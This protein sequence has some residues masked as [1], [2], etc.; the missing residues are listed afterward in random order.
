[1]PDPPTRP[2][3][4]NPS[5][6]SPKLPLRDTVKHK[7]WSLKGYIASRSLSSGTPLP[8]TSLRHSTSS[9]EGE[10]EDRERENPVR[11]SLPS[12]I[13]MEGNLVDV[14]QLME[15][16]ETMK[17]KLYKAMRVIAQIKV[18]REKGKIIFYLF[19]FFY[20]GVQLLLNWTKRRQ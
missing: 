7:N 8:S 2:H 4:N 11:S 12:E 10:S 5:P 9:I 13:G 3:P 17:N 20:F 18:Y 15:E 16:N 1:V 14:D 19:G 6:P